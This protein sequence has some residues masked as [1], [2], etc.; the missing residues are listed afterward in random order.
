MG[1]C[2]QLMKA[3]KQGKGHLAMPPPKKMNALRHEKPPGIKFSERG[4][5]Q[6]TCEKIAHGDIDIFAKY[7]VIYY[8][9]LQGGHMYDLPFYQNGNEVAEAKIIQLIVIKRR[10]FVVMLGC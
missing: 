5:K 2:V 8:L 3:H 1:Q 10:V 9:D 6:V 4:L 7:R